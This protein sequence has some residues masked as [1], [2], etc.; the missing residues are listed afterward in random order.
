LDALGRETGRQGEADRMAR[1]RQ[2]RLER[3]RVEE[4]IASGLHE[5]LQ[6]FIR[7][8]RLLNQAINEQFRF[9]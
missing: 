4:I 2:K 9:A 5:F 8:N 1:L 7:E 3:T 6:A